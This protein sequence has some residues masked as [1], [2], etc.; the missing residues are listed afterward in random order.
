MSLILTMWGKSRVHETGVLLSVGIRKAG[1]V[2]QYL[3]EVLLI[4]CFAFG[5][6]FFTSNA[7]ADGIANEL[8]RQ[9]VQSTQEQSGNP[10]FKAIPKDGASDIEISIKKDPDASPAG[11]APQE[12]AADTNREA[13]N[14]AGLS[15]AIGP[16]AMLQL[17][18]IGFAI[19]ILSVGI[20]SASVMRLNPK[21]ILSKMS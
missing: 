16:D 9:N 10:D 1:I 17:Y 8:L 19:I 20:S 5:L 3:A 12:G 13:D 18:L 2:G 21:K 15:V 4:A 7:I 6:S 14:A 11:N